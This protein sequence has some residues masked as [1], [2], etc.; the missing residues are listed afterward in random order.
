[1]FHETKNS[2]NEGLF[3]M[4]ECPI[5]FCFTL[6]ILRA[7]G[8]RH[9]PTTIAN[10]SRGKIMTIYLN[11]NELQHFFIGDNNSSKNTDW[12]KQKKKLNVIFDTRAAS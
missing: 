3:S 1:V 4:K 7:G 11:F 9:C 6:L 10:H 12:A 8:S 2:D 5:S